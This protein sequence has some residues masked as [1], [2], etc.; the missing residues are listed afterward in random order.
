MKIFIGVGFAV[1]MFFAM[2][3]V[4]N[5]WSNL[6]PGLHTLTKKQAFQGLVGMGVASLFFVLLLFFA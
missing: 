1:A 3:A 5:V 6:G 2:S 4:R